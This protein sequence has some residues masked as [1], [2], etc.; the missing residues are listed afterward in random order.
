MKI[1]PDHYIQTEVKKQMAAESP[2]DREK[3]LAVMKEIRRKE[4]NK[5]K[6]RQ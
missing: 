4:R 2:E 6:A 3:R 1:K 5:R